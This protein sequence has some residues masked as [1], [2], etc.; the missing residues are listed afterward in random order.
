MRGRWY[1]HLLVLWRPSK[2][3]RAGVFLP[4]RPDQCHEFFRPFRV[5]FGVGLEIL[6]AERRFKHEASWK[7]DLLA[8]RFP[9]FSLPWHFDFSLAQTILEYVIEKRLLLRTNEPSCKLL[10]LRH[11]PRYEPEGRVFESPRAQH[12]NRISSQRVAADTHAYRAN[13]ILESIVWRLDALH[14]QVNDRL[15]AVMRGVRETTP[16]P[17]EAGQ[18]AGGLADHGIHALRAH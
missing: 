17:F 3:D 5:M 10:F 6:G 12:L 13:R 14:A 8:A 1:P 15:S 16:K 9:F 2:S 11:P 7:P 18:M 4:K